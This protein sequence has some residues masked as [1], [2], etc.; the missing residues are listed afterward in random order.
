M[1]LNIREY[2]IF[3]CLPFCESANIL[4]VVPVSSRSHDI[5]LRPIGL[6]LA[7][8]GHNITVITS[9]DVPNSPENY[10]KVVVERKEIWDLM[11]TARP[12]I[13]ETTKISTIELINTILWKAG[14]AFT[15]HILNST[16]VQDFLKQ[17]NNYDL[18]ICETFVQDAIYYFS[19]RYNAPLVLVT[20]F[21]N[22][23]RH[24]IAVGNPL[25]LATIHY[26]FVPIEN[27]KSFLGRM[28][29]LFISIYEY[30]LWRFWYLKEQEILAKKYIKDLPEPVP[31]LYDTEKNAALFLVN[32]HF[33]FN[34]PMAYLP[35]IIEIGGLHTTMNAEPEILPKEIEKVLNESTNGI[36]YIN[37]GSNVKSSELPA[38]KRN[39]FI[40]ILGRLKH[41]VLWKWEN[42]LTKDM[43]QNIITRKWFPQHK[44]LA[45]PNI[46]LFIGHGGAMST[47][48]AVYHGVPILGVPVY[49]DQYNNLLLA[50][51]A[52]FG[53]ILN[54]NDINEA[55]TE[56][57]IKDIL[58]K[59]IYML[60]AKEVSKIFRDR[61][62]NPLETA[63]FWIEYVIRNNG[64][65]RM[66]SSAIDMH[67]TV[68]N[69]LDVYAFIVITFVAI[70]FLAVKLLIVLRNKLRY[71]TVLTKKQK[72]S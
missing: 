28:K 9:F 6:E 52:G 25:Q 68:F 62:M 46:K 23:M 53:E 31:N 65:N 34:E 43:P 16:E 17:D 1:M 67:W 10:H 40:S 20:P 19:H 30:V 29:N 54:F 57:A 21:G 37:F 49:A 2:I 44:I 64:T 4:Y 13:F 35:N 66:K 5:F 32:R 14:L 42:D 71:R 3:L 26:E 63:M 15:E 11:G 24:N 39:A 27:P 18:V 50:K 33:S 36:V 56:R 59:D 38:D 69:M 72:R 61:P 12:N 60:K 41:T 51:V 45:H 22:C 7:N 55:S 48:E 70:A 8:R 47:Q 58:E